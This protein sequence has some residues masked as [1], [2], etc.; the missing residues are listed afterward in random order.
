MT[1][2]LIGNWNGVLDELL[3]CMEYLI[4]DVGTKV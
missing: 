2:V 1:L 3:D 4:V